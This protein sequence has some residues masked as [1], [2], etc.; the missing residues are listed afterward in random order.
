MAVVNTSYSDQE[1]RD[2][3]AAAW[4]VEPSG[5][6]AVL[7]GMVLRKKPLLQCQHINPI[8]GGSKDLAE[9]LHQMGLLK[10]AGVPETIGALAVLE[11][12]RS[13]ANGDDETIKG[14]AARKT[15]VLDV[16]TRFVTKWSTRASEELAGD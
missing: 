1:I 14:L 3:V 13:A 10:E 9:M 6:R 15:E 4:R 5:T 11:A 8:P 2:K 12:M 7:R 16:L